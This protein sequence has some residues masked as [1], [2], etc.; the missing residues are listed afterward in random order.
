MATRGKKQAGSSGRIKVGEASG[1]SLGANVDDLLLA[2]LERGGETLE[3]GRMVVSYAEGRFDEGV[4]SLKSMSLRVADARDFTDQAMTMEGAGDADA[5]FLPEIGVAVIGGNAVA[6][7]GITAQHSALTS[8]AVQVVEP[9]YFVFADSA[10][11]LRG[12]AAAANTIARDLGAQRPEGAPEEEPGVE[13]L[14]ATW[15]LNACRV[16]PSTRSGAGMK[17]AVLDTGFD[18]GH[19]DF[20]GRSVTTNTFVGQPVQDLH[21]HGT[22]CIGTACGPRAPAGT[23]P[24]YGIAYGCRIFVGKVLSNSGGGSVPLNFSSCGL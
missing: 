14:G 22:H 12:F 18:L 1:A 11:Y 5:M 23:T 8:D 24:R 15:G 6:A 16:P 21:G 7:R 9:E 17:V 3:T 2:A 4:K 10:E 20:V 19:P 13:V